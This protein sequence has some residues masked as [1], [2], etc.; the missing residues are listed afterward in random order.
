MKIKICGLTQPEEAAYLNKNKVDFAGF[1]MFCPKSKRNVSVEQAAEIMKKLSPDIKKVAVVVAPTEEQMKLIEAAG[2]DYIQ[3]HGKVA[4]ELI[5]G[6]SLPVLKAF[7]VS[8]I[9]EFQHY[10]ELDNIAGYVFDAGEPGSGKVFDWDML[11]DI[12]RDDRLFVL[13]GGLTPANVAQAIAY[14]R[15]D[16]VDVSSGVEYDDKPGKDPEK[17]DGFVDEA[18]K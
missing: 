7:N 12:E 18:S 8:D 6:S 14:V 5:S 3:I 4:D 17:V 15:P 11:K 1:V 9:E 16:A 10:K 13:A 2:F